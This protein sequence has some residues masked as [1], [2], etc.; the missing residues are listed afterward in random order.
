MAKNYY[1]LL[2]VDRGADAAKIKHAYR[3]I[4]KQLHPDRSD[5]SADAERFMEAKEA[6]DTLV[7]A[8]RRR[9]YDDELARRES[10]PG[11]ARVP[12]IVRDRSRLY[13][14]FERREA[15]VDDVFE[16]WVPGFYGH[17]RRGGFEKDLYLEVVLSS[18]E[19]HEGG[20]FP[21]RF[22]VV[23][24]CPQCRRTGALDEFFCPVCAGRGVVSTEREFSLSIPPRTAGGTAVSLSLED[25]GLK[26]VQL[27]VA[28][29]VDP[30]L[31]D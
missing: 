25:I 1:I 2:G 31:E 30:W 12:L 3:R 26:D 28:L 17:S 5:P 18:R 11:I 14:E 20:L 10:S 7:D 6:Y 24:P 22:P 21:I 15:L 23:E 29:H 19:A 4:A 27:H 13:R 16:G 9:R 8:E